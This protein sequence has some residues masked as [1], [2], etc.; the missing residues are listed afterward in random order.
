MAQE[1]KNYRIENE[2]GTE[3]VLQLDGEDAKRWKALA[4]EK[5]SPVKKVTEADPKPI[6]ASG[7]R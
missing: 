3:Q 4:D 1:L 2:D 5:A 7:S 6:N